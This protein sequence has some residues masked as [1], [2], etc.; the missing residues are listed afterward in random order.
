MMAQQCN[1]EVG[2]FVWTGG[3]VHLYSNH[4]E[5]AREQLTREPKALP[6]LKINRKPES[7][8]DYVYEDFELVGYESHPIIKAPIAI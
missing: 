5:Q 4:L 7:I 2:K 8:F 3:D 1:L 6:T